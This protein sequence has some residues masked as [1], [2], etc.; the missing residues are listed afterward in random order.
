M[1]IWI[2]TPIGVGVVLFF[3][4]LFMAFRTAI[5]VNRFSTKVVL[6]VILTILSIGWISIGVY[7]YFIIKSQMGN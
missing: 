7:A 1:N 2:F 6:N 5:K 3:Y 4:S